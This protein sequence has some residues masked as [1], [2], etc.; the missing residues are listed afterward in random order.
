[1][2]K[3]LK[4]YKTGNKKKAIGVYSDKREV[5][6]M[7]DEYVAPLGDLMED[8]IEHQTK[9]FWKRKYY[10]SHLTKLYKEMLNTIDIERGF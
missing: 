9:P 4:K 3:E 6:I 7:L 2:Y 1:M 10:H 5:E 8:F